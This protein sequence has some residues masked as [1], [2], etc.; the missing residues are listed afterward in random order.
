MMIK[1]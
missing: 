1:E